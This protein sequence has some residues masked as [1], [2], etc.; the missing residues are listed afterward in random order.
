[1]TRFKTL[2]A[3]GKSLFAAWMRFAHLLAIVNTT[4]ILTLVYFLLIGPIALIMRIIRNDPLERRMK[5]VETFWRPKESVP[6]S[7]EEVRRQF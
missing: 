7:L 1:M 2:R 4:I 3:L 5:G 6:H